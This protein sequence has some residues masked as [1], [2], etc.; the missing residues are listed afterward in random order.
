[1]VENFADHPKTVGEIR[2][3]KTQLAREWAPRDVLIE[4]LRLI[5]SGKKV[6]ALVVCW[7]ETIEGR[8]NG[9]YRLSSPN[10]L[11]ALGM[12]SLAAHQIGNQLK[13]E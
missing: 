4:M 5:D 10:C 2:A 9:F 12:L 11:T 6:D 7:K 3:N 8:E 13:S 1:M